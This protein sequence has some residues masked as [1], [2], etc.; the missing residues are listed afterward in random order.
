MHSVFDREKVLYSFIEHKDELNERNK[1]GIEK[2]TV[3][4]YGSKE[5]AL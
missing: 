4:L 2:Y 1:N 3:M 5:S